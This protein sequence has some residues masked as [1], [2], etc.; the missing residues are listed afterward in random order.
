MG[1]IHGSLARAGK[2]KSQTPV[3]EKKD[4]KKQPKGRALRRLKYNQRMNKK[5]TDFSKKF[6]KP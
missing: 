1:K 6:N 4:K 3:V 2:V 5:N